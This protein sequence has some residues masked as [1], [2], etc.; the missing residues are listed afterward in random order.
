MVLYFFMIVA[1][2]LFEGLSYT[3]AQERQ[4][5]GRINKI[6]ENSQMAI[7]KR[8][9]SHRVQTRG[10]SKGEAIELFRI[11]AEEGNFEAQF[12]LGQIYFNGFWGVEKDLIIGMKWWLMSSDCGYEPAKKAIRYLKAQMTNKEF[13]QA[14][15]LVVEQGL[16]LCR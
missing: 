8:P 15:R 7:E 11:E 12:M 5:L 10:F 2:S 13:A 14:K 16:N 4:D 9:F 3:H 1:L 6:I